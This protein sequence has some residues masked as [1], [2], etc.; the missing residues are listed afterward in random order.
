M[1]YF[2]RMESTV[3]NRG[4]CADSAEVHIYLHFH[5]L[6]FLFYL[7][8][9]GFGS[10]ICAQGVK[11]P[12][13]SVE[14]L[15]FTYR[16]IFCSLRCLQSGHVAHWRRIKSVLNQP[17]GCRYNAHACLF[18]P[19]H[20][21]LLMFGKL[22]NH[23]HPPLLPQTNLHMRREHHRGVRSNR[24]PGVPRSL[25]SKHQMCVENHS[26]SNI[27]IHVFCFHCPGN[28]KVIKLIVNLLIKNTPNN[29]TV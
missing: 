1:Q 11:D 28:D 26:E 23:Y 22:R 9:Y 19:T 4:L 2:L 3:F 27:P 29:C 20:L 14:K 15:E 10:L 24:E 13:Q 17:A 7:F 21:C 25:P 16:G 6:L 18:I 8:S 5:L 12:M